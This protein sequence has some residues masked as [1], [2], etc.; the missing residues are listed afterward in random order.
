M[1]RRAG[2]LQGNPAVEAAVGTIRGSARPAPGAPVPLEALCLTHADMG[3]YSPA[4][5]RA[6]TTSDAFNAVAEPR[7][8]ELLDVLA[9]G[10]RSVGELAQSLRVAQPVVSK[11]LRV[12]RDVKLVARRDQGRQRLYRLNGA[13]LRPIHEW[14]RRYEESWSGAFDRMEMVLQTLEAQEERQHG[15]GAETQGSGHAARR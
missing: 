2:S 12:L 4:V 14:L 7:R 15:Q 6:S 3:M 11:H 5:A 13:A 9:G 1:A 10:E 8:R